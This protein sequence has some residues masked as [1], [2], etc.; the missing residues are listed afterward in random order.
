MSR[1]N[2]LEYQEY[3]SYATIRGITEKLINLDLIEVNQI[4]KSVGNS[5]SYSLT[6]KGWSIIF[7]LEKSGERKKI[8]TASAKFSNTHLSLF[9]KEV[10]NLTEDLSR[11]VKISRYNDKI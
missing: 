1:S 5:L 3:F 9:T 11:P 4:Y 8:E 6:P 2:I 7:L 10:F